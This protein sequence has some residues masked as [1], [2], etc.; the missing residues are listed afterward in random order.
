MPAA[1]P[2][3]VESPAI[4]DQFMAL[5]AGAGAIN[6]YLAVMCCG[7]S[8]H[9]VNIIAPRGSCPPEAAPQ[10]ALKAASKAKLL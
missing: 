5:T 4:D 6:L 3:L 8:P 9:L 10:R 7:K 1:G 2:I